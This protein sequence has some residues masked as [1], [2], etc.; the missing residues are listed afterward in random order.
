MSVGLPVFSPDGKSLAVACMVSVDIYDLSIMPV[1]GGGAR[2]IARVDGLSD[3]A[4]AAD[5]RHV[6][7]AAGGDLSRVSAAGGEP[8]KLLS[9]RDAS[10]MAVSR[11]GHRAAYA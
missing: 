5:G 7:F 9:G 10:G 4:W 2:R 11:T 1:L 3:L 6:L 8:E